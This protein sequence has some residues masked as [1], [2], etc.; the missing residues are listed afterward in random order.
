MLGRTTSSSSTAAATTTAGS[1]VE[2]IF[3]KR[4]PVPAS[5]EDVF[6]YHTREGALERL[7]PPWSILRATSHQGGIQDGA[8]STFRVQLGP[9][10]FNWTA[11]HF[12]YL[13][14]RQFQDR[15]V[16]G[17]LKSWVHTHSF[18]PEGSDY[19]I[20]EDKIKFTSPLGNLGSIFTNR[21]IQNNL[22]QLFHYRHRIL[23]NDIGL[24]KLAGK[25]KG[26][27]ILITGSSGLIGS[28]LVPLLKVAGEHKITRLSRPS[29]NQDYQHLASDAVIVWDPNNDKI[30]ARDLEGFDV[31]IH[32]AGESIFGR[33][34]ESKKQKILQ[35]RVK[36]TRLLCNSLSKLANPP[37]TLVCASAIGYYGNRGT[38]ILTEES[39]PGDGFLPEVCQQWEQSTESAREAGI[40][41][42]NTRFG[43]VLSPRGGILQ[44]L[45]LPSRF[46]LGLKLADA[47]QHISWVSM[48]DVIGSIFFSII[49][50]S[51]KGAVNV[52]SPNPVT[53]LDFS[54]LLAKIVKSK[55]MLLPVNK[56]LAK[57][58]FG[59]LADNLINSSALVLPNKLL[60]TGYKFVNPN[61]GDALMLLL[62]RHIIS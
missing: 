61:L 29:S 14:Y 9:L 11:E 18:I 16:K 1:S 57:L 49:N 52:V 62:G 6:D 22:D 28:S 33:W 31:V 44:K 53:A 46:G 4:T 20:M 26:K 54:E 37:D 15:M 5:A 23:T 32:L 38:E 40:R 34:S 51:I 7:V 10:R 19:C 24:W 13:Q 50:S 25:N 27:R 42:V 2:C 41:V 35:S 55:I 17:P 59:E 12:G 48:E 39:G 45:I 21:M 56:D 8:V 30:N 36:H 58:V 60:S 3:V 43:V 47:N